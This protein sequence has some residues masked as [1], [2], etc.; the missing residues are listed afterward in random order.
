MKRLKRII[1]NLFITIGFGTI[2]YLPAL[3]IANGTDNTLKSVLIW[4]IAS[5][6]YGFSFE[7]LNITTKL[8]IFVHIIVCFAITIAARLLFAYSSQSNADIFHT[9]LITIPIFIGVYGALF[10]FMKLIGFRDGRE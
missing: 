4:V 6:L 8:K 5:A 7:L 1:R 3:M 9:F 10:I 2:V